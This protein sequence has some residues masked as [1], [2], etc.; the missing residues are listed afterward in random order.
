M[1]QGNRR[2]CYKNLAG[3]W[4]RMYARREQYKQLTLFDGFFEVTKNLDT[5]NRWVRMA[6]MMPWQSI[7]E[8]YAKKF[9]DIG[10]G[11]KPVRLALGSLIIKEKLGLTDRETIQQITENPYMQYFV[12]LDQFTNKTLFDHSM[13][14][15]FRKRFDEQTLTEINARL[16]VLEQG[17]PEDEDSNDKTGSDGTTQEK[18]EHTDGQSE[19]SETPYEEN[20]IDKTTVNHENR[21][22]ILL[23]G[24]CA[25]ADIRF[26]TDVSLLDEARMVLERVI[27]ELHEQVRDGIEKPRTYR[28]LARA[29]YIDFIKSRKPAKKKVQKAAKQQLRYIRRNLKTIEKLLE[30]V[31]LNLSKRLYRLLLVANELYRQQSLKYL[32]GQSKIEN[33]IVSLH[34]PHIRPIVRGKAG[35]AVEFGAK[36]II[37]VT[38]GF[39][40]VEQISFDNIAEGPVL[41][42]ACE[43]YFRRHGCYPATVI[44]DRAY[45]SNENR[46]YCE[47]KGIRLSAPKR[48][49]KKQSEQAELKKQLALDS[50]LRNAVEGRIGVAKRRYGLDKIFSKLVETSICEIMMQFIVSNIERGLALLFGQIQIWYHMVFFRLVRA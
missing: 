32:K 31:D 29:A 17:S 47:Q 16:E 39:T 23:D 46:K 37:S 43:N 5:E 22:T 7:E 45:Q 40:H 13:M 36:L 42:R 20:T 30:L 48:G 19:A 33:R 26:P 11:A 14:T 28:E 4:T 24:T 9:A 50:R 34:Q 2:K 1:V 49:R 21:G 3:E 41:Q 6:N 35:N 27:D 8:A 44:G 25:P 38:N 18:L 10:A 15:H 12:G